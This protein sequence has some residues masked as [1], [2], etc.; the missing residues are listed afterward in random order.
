MKKLV[1]LL[2]IVTMAAAGVFGATSFSKSEKKIDSVE[3]AT[4]ID[5]YFTKPGV[6]TYDNAW[7]DTINLHYWG[8]S[9]STTFPGVAMTNAYVNASSQQVVKA[10]IS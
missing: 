1:K 6:N 3:A 10:S 4:T 7:N 8:G 5:I 2:S 9:S